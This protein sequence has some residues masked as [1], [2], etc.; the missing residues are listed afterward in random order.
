V[1]DRNGA[2]YQK[3]KA[4]LFMGAN[5]DTKLSENVQ[6]KLFPHSPHSTYIAWAAILPAI[7]IENIYRLAALAFC[8]AHFFSSAQ[9]IGGVAKLFHGPSPFDPLPE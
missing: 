1:E 4:L 5:Q 8:L 7:S 6:A 3:K 2:S 9:Q